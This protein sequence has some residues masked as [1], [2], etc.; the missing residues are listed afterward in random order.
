MDSPTPGDY[1]ALLDLHK[2]LKQEYEEVKQD[3]HHVKRKQ[4][5]NEALIFE[6]RG[7]IEILQAEKSNGGLKYEKKISSLEE[8]L[9]I[10]RSSHSQTT[11]H[12][13]NDLAKKEEEN[14]TLKAE[15]EILK[16]K[17]ALLEE[18]NDV[19]L[20][21]NE[22]DIVAE[23]EILRENLEKLQ[24]DYEMILSRHHEMDEKLI[25]YREEIC[26]LKESLNTKREE[27]LEKT[28]L[29]DQLND[30]LFIIN[31]ELESLKNKPLQKES[32][33][34]SLFAEVDDRRV[35]LQ[36]TVNDMKSS[37]I[38]L[39]HEH[40]KHEQIIAHLRKENAELQDLWKK[41]L[42]EI[43]E[44]RDGIIHSLNDRIQI[45]EEIN[46]RQTRQL[47]EDLTPPSD[48]LCAEYMFY[49]DMIESKNEEI[50]K[51]GK[52]LSDRTITE[53][54]LS[55]SVAQAHKKIQLMRLNIMELEQQI[56]RNKEE[57]LLTR[58]NQMYTRLTMYEE[59]L[60]GK[61]K[62]EDESL[63]EVSDLKSCLKSVENKLR[64]SPQ[65]LLEDAS[66]DTSINTSEDF[67]KADS[68]PSKIKQH[69]NSNAENKENRTSNITKRKGVQFSQGV[70]SP[71]LN[72]SRRR[73]TQIHI[74]ENN[75]LDTTD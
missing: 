43:Q 18:N 1:N 71:A 50:R 23:N 53:H 13:E 67:V 30:D 57:E 46:K 19:S 24:D 72:P 58:E 22:P 64:L 60:G 37:Y 31:S 39:K 4:K 17:I 10:L 32:K 63:E 54:M 51:L 56:E 6:Y 14:E 66:T 75:D 21:L 3:L 9:N 65:N 33:G 73:S 68:S 52:K 45:L 62:E 40:S 41:D 48:D 16:Q 38:Y 28:L 26:E 15:L 2:N 34:N 7:E 12:L 35:H 8:A 44:D 27:L 69:Q 11:S 70:V 29:I 55:A 74:V 5:V 36:K 20:K 47:E 49:Q 42:E 59:E 25:E 61:S